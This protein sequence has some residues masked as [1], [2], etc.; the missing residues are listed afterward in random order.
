MPQG[1]KIR[2]AIDA[3]GGDFA[4]FSVVAGAVLA[5][6]TYG[7]SIE[8]ILVGDSN[9]IKGELESLNASHVPLQIAHATEI[10]GMADEPAES[11]RKKPNSSIVVGL[12][13]QSQGKC[14]AFISAGNTGAVMAA[15]LL[16]LGRLKGVNRPAIGT[17]FPTEKGQAL[18]LDVGANS[19]CKAVNLYQFGGNFIFWSTSEAVSSAFRNWPMAPI[20]VLEMTAD[21]PPSLETYTAMFAGEPPWYL[22]NV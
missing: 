19:D 3:M 7:E 13:Y 8:Q 15:S 17:F 11:V 9:R 4:P 20:P 5:H 2:I 18:V 12:N 22:R 14:D 6:K 10:I 16:V 21:L 1:R